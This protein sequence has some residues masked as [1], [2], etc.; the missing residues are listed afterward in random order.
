MLRLSMSAPA[1]PDRPLKICCDEIRAWRDRLRAAST[2][3]HVASDP[4]TGTDGIFS[5]AARVASLGSTGLF[6]ALE[7]EIYAAR[8][9]ARVVSEHWVR[10]IGLTR[11]TRSSGESATGDHYWKDLRRAEAVRADKLV[12]EWFPDGLATSS[13]PEFV[14]RQI[15]DLRLAPPPTAGEVKAARATIEK[16]SFRAT[17]RALLAPLKNKTVDDH[18]S[19]ASLD[20]TYP[21]LSGC[22]HGGPE[23]HKWLLDSGASARLA[24][25]LDIATVWASVLV[26]VRTHQAAG[27]RNS[28]AVLEAFG[29]QRD[30]VLWHSI[31]AAALA[32]ATY[33]STVEAARARPGGTSAV[34][35]DK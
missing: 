7:G 34:D 23:A 26:F 8:T 12:R 10:L 31:A 17:V 30:V 21:G 32:V 27:D 4:R 2:G 18:A 35:V 14:R 13:L 5:I 28:P 6:A 22:I 33:R 25:A 3:L 16:Y 19:F 15:Q 29:I 24:A 1:D 9:L 20:L 11:D